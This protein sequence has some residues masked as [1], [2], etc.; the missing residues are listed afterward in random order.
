MYNPRVKHAPRKQFRQKTEISETVKIIEGPPLSSVAKIA[1][2]RET[3]FYSYLWF[4]TL[5]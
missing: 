2:F 3:L 4:L 1:I 5:F